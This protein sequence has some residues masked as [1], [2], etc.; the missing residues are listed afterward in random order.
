MSTTLLPS[1]RAT[2]VLLVA[3]AT[4]EVA[5][6]LLSPLAGTSTRRDL[7]A[8]A[9]HQ[10]V[11]Q[12]S[13]LIGLV[14]TVLFLPGF[15]GLAQA[16]LTLSPHLARV[17][18]WVAAFSMAGFLA[19]RL[20]QAVELATAQTGGDR[21]DAAA[22]IDHVGATSIGAPILV[23]FLGGALVGLVL[24]AVVGWRAALPRVAC[25]L[26]AVFQPLD[27]TLPEDRFPLSAV[28]HA[29]LLVA[30]V[31]IAQGLWRRARPVTEPTV[32]AAAPALR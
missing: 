16:C 13:V 28:S 18:G 25:I 10:G 2:A 24:F 23:M 11:F 29:L 19:V 20:G 5:E 1:R 31:L 12:V 21:H 3:A 14:A 8:I 27:L 6:Q 15:L 26:L 30:M 22:A 9:A 4:G 7:D 17:A 32:A